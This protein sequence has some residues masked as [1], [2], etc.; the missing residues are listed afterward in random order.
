MRVEP[1]QESGKPA[2]DDFVRRS[3][4]GTFLFLRDYMEYHRDRF[5][6]CSLVILEDDGRIVCLLPAHA[7]DGV[8]VSHGGLTYG[9][10]VTDE[11]MKLPKMLEVFEQTLRFFQEQSIHRLVYKCVPHIYH[12]ATAEEDLS[13]LFLC[14][15]RLL[16]RGGL[17][18]VKSSNRLPFQE[19]R[20][21][22]ARKGIKSGIVVRQSEDLASYWEILTERLRQGYDTQ[23]VHGL[24]EMRMLHQR[25]PD[26][27]KL[28]AAYQ[29]ERML[30][31]VIIYESET[32]AHAQYIAGNEASRDLGALDLIFDELLTKHYA[33]KPYFDFG[34]SD[35]KD[36]R[37]LNRG[38]ID[39]KEGYG[40]RLVAQDQYEVDVANWTPGQLM[41]ALT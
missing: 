29:E 37:V 30:A 12:R 5:A 2:W 21:R 40:A 18:V 17:A 3:K 19:R 11:Q 25:F 16:R 10:F 22:G 35:E 4:N 38:L 8:A 6:D 1:Y 14:N 27:I 28:F 34:T 9:G 7:S 15:A 26:N 23:P 36:G 24:E 33:T 32:V 39:Q 31:G 41:G 13:A 20:R